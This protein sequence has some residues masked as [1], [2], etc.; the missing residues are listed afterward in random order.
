[1][2]GRPPPLCPGS[3]SL[4]CLFAAKEALDGKHPNQQT[5]EGSPQPKKA[6]TARQIVCVCVC[7]CVGICMGHEAEQHWGPEAASETLCRAVLRACWCVGCVC[8]CGVVWT[9]WCR[10]R[11]AVAAR[12]YCGREEQDPKIVGYCRQHTVN[13]RHRGTGPQG[14]C[15]APRVA[16]LAVR[17]SASF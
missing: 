7:V 16:M 15:Q 10:L 14:H 8:G 5:K 13:C 11:R 17:R 12:E 2:E 4:A 3:S 6:C 9:V 1:M